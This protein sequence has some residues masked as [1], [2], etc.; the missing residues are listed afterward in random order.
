MEVQADIRTVHRIMATGGE[1]RAAP[2]K[3]GVIGF[4]NDELPG[5]ELHLGVT[6]Q[7]QVIVGLHEHLA[8]DRSMRLMANRAPLAQG[9]MVVNK[10]AR[11]FAMARCAGLILASHGQAT[12]RFHDVLS[13]RIVALNTIHPAFDHGMMLRKMKFG[14][15][16]DVTPKARS[17]I[18]PR[19][20]DE[21]PAS[22]AHGYMFAARP[23]AGFATGHCGPLEIVLVESAMRAGMKNPR[24]VGMAIDTLTVPNECRSLNLRGRQHCSIEG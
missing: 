8:V 6:A 17:R 2:D 13:M 22:A 1:A 20:H 4:P 18:A 14:F 23:V 24:D 19:I 10:T 11:L 5:G 3:T 21:P 15:N 7:T 12:G 9:F 16:L